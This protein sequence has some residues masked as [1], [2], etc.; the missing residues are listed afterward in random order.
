[1]VF[2]CSLLQ[3]LVSANVVPSSQ[4]LF[5]LMMEAVR[6]PEISVLTR[7]TWSNI[8]HNDILHSYRCEN[9]KTLT[10]SDFRLISPLK[11]WFG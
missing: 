7:A 10:I 11:T 5:T 6:S 4:I 1:M 2:L 9:I 8:P 3:L